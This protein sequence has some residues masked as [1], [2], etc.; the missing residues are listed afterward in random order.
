MVNTFQFKPRIAIEPT[1]QEPLIPTGKITTSDCPNLLVKINNTN[2][3]T[4]KLQPVDSTC[5]TTSPEKIL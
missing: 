4:S 3:E 5:E 1:T 2:I